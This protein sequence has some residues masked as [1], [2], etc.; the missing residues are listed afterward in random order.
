MF[1]YLLTY[2]IIICVCLTFIL[3]NYATNN[4][5]FKNVLKYHKKEKIQS[6]TPL[7][8]ILVPAR[9]EE[10]DIEKCIRSL[11]NQDYPNMEII[12]L[13]D[14][15]IDNTASI[16]RRLSHESSKVK[17]LK[18]KPL[19]Q[20]WVGK[21]YGC[22]QLEK[23]ARGDY[24]LFTDADTIHEKNSVS[25]A[26]L[27]LKENKLDALSVYPFQIT[28]SVMEKMI[29]RYINLGI[30]L[31]IPLKL[32]Q[33]TSTKLFSTALGSLMLYKRKVYRAVGGHT[34]ISGQCL[35]D[36]NMSI[37]LK[38]MGYNFMIFDGTHTYRTRMY[39]D[40]PSIIKGI[41]RFVLTTFNFNAFMG[42]MNML[43]LSIILLFPFLMIPVSMLTG[44]GSVY[45]LP[46]LIIHAIQI[47]III[48]IRVAYLLRFKGTF[49]EILLHPA[50]IG[51]LLF[52][53]IY[54]NI[55]P[56]KGQCIDWKGRKYTLQQQHI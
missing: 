5:L 15:S 32:M 23:E 20:G 36:I 41:K 1:P 47:L 38:K 11:I 48:S 53:S 25:S 17:I 44:T 9:N 8:S 24:L 13:D 49:S 46:N 21:N 34:S 6:D 54:I 16:I 35:E 28:K 29:I 22:Y 42:F 40:F 31:F 27:C 3:V 43:L 52:L 10:K 45:Y 14:N 30:L 39:D 12:I 33:K 55:N 18:G 50:S 56:K 19:P 4:I 7:I 51:L 37:L 2:N 26:F